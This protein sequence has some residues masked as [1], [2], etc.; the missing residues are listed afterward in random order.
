MGLMQCGPKPTIFTHTSVCRFFAGVLVGWALLSSAAAFGAPRAQFRE[1]LID[2]GVVLPTA[3]QRHEFELKNSG[4]AELQVLSV[5]ASCGCTTS[6]EWDRVIAPGQTGRIPI[7]FDPVSFNGAITKAVVVTTNDPE[8]PVRSLEI[9]A[10]VRRPFDIEPAITSFL[11]VEGEA[12]NETK[13]VRLTSNDAALVTLAAPESTNPQFRPELREIVR[14]REFVLLITYDVT[15]PQ[16]APNALIS[17]R[18]S[19][20]EQP[21]LRISA[22]ALPQPALAVLPAEIRLPAGPLPG[23]NIH[24]I[25]IRNHSATPLRIFDVVATDD[26]LSVSVDEREPG[27]QFF[28]NVAFPRGYN[29]VEQPDASVSVKTSHPKFPVVRVPI[30]VG[31][32][33]RASREAQD[34][35][36]E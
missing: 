19:H 10:R 5:S 31:T 25:L 26:R 23:N 24:R 33:P 4:D 11:P 13:L 7:E 35:G 6:G 20:P 36:H 28:L 16:F 27:K 2:F 3:V 32:A 8:Q 29:A 30:V 18:T 1:T 14:G 9:R 17:I 34:A 22:L 12:R 15:Q 21:I